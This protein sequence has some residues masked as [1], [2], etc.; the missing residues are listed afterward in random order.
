[1]AAQRCMHIIE[2]RQ[3]ATGA[4][5]TAAHGTL[6]GQL[7]AS[8]ATFIAIIKPDKQCVSF[9]GCLVLNTHSQLHTHT[10]THVRLEW[11]TW[12]FLWII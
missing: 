6:S 4:G 9:G 2:Y 3:A 10:H 7:F 8:I 5:E 1:M 11:L 12:Y